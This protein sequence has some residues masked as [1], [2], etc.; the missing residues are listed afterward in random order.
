M[1]NL[2]IEATKS[3]PQIRFD[4]ETRILELQ[5][6]SYPENAIKFYEPVLKWI[7]HYLADVPEREVI[8]N[9]EILYFN[10]STSKVFMNLFDM[11]DSAAGQGRPVTINW[12]FHEENE[13]AGECGEEF[14]E[15]LD[16]IDFN[17]VEFGDR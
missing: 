14:M 12:R 6:E 1:E 16:N 10:S 17:L 5:G 3:S 15:E 7:E 13:I 8:L 2:I 9:M 11:L 4:S